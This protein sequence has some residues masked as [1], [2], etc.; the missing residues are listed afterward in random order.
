MPGGLF[1]KILALIGDL[2]RR[3]VRAWAEKI[4][5]GVKSAGEVGLGA[6]KFGKQASNES[7]I[8]KSGLPR[9]CRAKFLPS[10]DGF[11]YHWL[12]YECCLGNI[13]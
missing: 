7:Q 9:D 11:A 2:R 1:Q 3:P 8:T 4:D 10:M 6:D 13:G 12:Q 5:D